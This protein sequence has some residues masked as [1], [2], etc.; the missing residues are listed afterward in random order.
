MTRITKKGIHGHRQRLQHKDMFSKTLGAIG[1]H[2]GSYR[3]YTIVAS[4]RY[5]R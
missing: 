4:R 2:C 3:D 5:K 1:T